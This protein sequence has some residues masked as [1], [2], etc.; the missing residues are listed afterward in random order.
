MKFNADL[1]NCDTTNKE[2]KN[3]Y[4][5]TSLHHKMHHN[6]LSTL[7]PLANFQYNINLVHV[8]LK[9]GYCSGFFDTIHSA[10]T[11]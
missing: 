6:Q 8:R 2:A 1:P 7:H 3:T 5:V 11:I 10:D 4:K 9:A